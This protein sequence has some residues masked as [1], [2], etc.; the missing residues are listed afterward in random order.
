[1]NI[2]TILT[3]AALVAVVWYVVKLVGRG[4]HMS[5]EVTTTSEARSSKPRIANV[6]QEFKWPALGEY[7][8]DVVGE[9]SYQNSIAALAAGHGTSSANV[10]CVAQLIPED[11]NKRDS[12]AVAV[13]I[14]GAL[15]GYLSRE[16]ARSFRRRLSQKGISGQATT[17]DACIVGGGTRKNGEKLYYGVKL[18]IKPFGY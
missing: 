2:G 4:S 7:D 13:R 16:D 9:A 15:V 12:K 17:C 8:F 10:Q 11:T 6:Q 5:N 3:L 14:Q 18:D 1:M